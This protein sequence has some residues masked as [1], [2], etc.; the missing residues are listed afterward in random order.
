MIILQGPVAVTE[1]DQWH[2]IGGFTSIIDSKYWGINHGV[3]IIKHYH[4]VLKPWLQT[5]KVSASSES[6][7]VLI[8]DGFP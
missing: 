5:I 3:M 6:K 7:A 8:F 4:C 2:H 1:K